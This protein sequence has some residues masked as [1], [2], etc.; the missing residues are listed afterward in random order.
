MPAGSSVGRAG[1]RR[2]IRIHDETRCVINPTNLSEEGFDVRAS[3]KDSRGEEREEQSGYDDQAAKVV[4]QYAGRRTGYDS[5]QRDVDKP[6]VVDVG[7][8]FR[9]SHFVCS[10]ERGQL[11][12]R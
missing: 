5:S 12:L 7:R 8:R 10:R 6:G 11:A 3:F 9:L 1:G 4:R 2:L